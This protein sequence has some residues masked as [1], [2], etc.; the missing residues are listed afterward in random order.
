MLLRIGGSVQ[1]ETAYVAVPLPE[2]LLFRNEDTKTHSRR[3]VASCDHKWG[4][5]SLRPLSV[6]GLQANNDRLERASRQL[7]QTFEIG[8][9]RNVGQPLKEPLRVPR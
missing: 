5:T 1:Q 8:D 6:E 7:I 3:G 4:K 9:S 2:P